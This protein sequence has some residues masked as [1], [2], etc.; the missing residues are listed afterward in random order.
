[1]KMIILG[2]EMF[3]GSLD[4]NTTYLHNPY[5]LAPKPVQGWQGWR[6]VE[7]SNGMEGDLPGTCFVFKPVQERVE[8]L[9]V[10]NGVHS[11]P[12]INSKFILT[13]SSGEILAVEEPIA[14]VRQFEVTLRFSSTEL[15]QEYRLYWPYADSLGYLGLKSPAE[16]LEGVPYVRPEQ[17][18]I[19]FGD[20]ITQ[21]YQGSHFLKSYAGRT[22]QKL[23]LPIYSMGF[24]SR[25]VVATD[26]LCESIP[27]PAFVSVLIGVN[28]A[29]GGTSLADYQKEIEE[30]YKNLRKRFPTVPI[31]WLVPFIELS[32]PGFDP[33]KKSGE[34]VISRVKAYQDF[35]FQWLPSLNDKALQIVDTRL[36]QTKEL[37][38]DWVHPQDEGHE[39][40]SNKILEAAEKLKSS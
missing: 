4:L 20:S 26:P 7:T 37:L 40:L 39:I 38:P 23:G 17:F 11:H 18:Y 30:Y 6:G 29:L 32:F 14:G 16:S 15:N 12:A 33:E 5:P 8:F 27:K 31:A 9:F 22:S 25:T 36:I 21:G 13:Q 1:M 34:G 24:G 28:N 19:P 35:L 3:N 2:A 10:R